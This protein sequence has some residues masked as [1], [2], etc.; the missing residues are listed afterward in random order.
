[1]PRGSRARRPPLG[2]HFL[3]DPAIL[4]KIARATGAGPGDTVLEIGPGQGTLT[5]A[6]LQ[7]GARVVAIEK[8]RRLAA[9]LEQR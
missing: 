8:D 9:Q 2:Q 6:L 4:S 1:M 5:E 3:A 7:T